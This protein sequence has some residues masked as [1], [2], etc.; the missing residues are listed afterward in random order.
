MQIALC[1]L[2]ALALSP[3]YLAAIECFVACLHTNTRTQSSLALFVRCI[4][5][6]G[7]QVGSCVQLLYKNICAMKGVMH[8]FR[9]EHK[10]TKP[11]THTHAYIYIY[12]NF[13]KQTGLSK[14]LQ[15]MRFITD[16]QLYVCTCTRVCFNICIYACWHLHAYVCIFAVLCLH[17]Y[18][19]YFACSEHARKYEERQRKKK[20]AKSKHKNPTTTT[21]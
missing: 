18:T 3:R 5:V 9:Y 7:V 4:R 21:K 10:Q 2:R 8:E 6:W 12:F 13:C 17:C 1:C 20:K 15:C 11:C 14:A 16:A 19:C